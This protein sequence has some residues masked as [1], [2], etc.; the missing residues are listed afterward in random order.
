MQQLRSIHRF[1]TLGIGVFL[2]FLGVTGTAVQLID[3]RSIAFVNSPHDPNVLAMREA[4]DGPGTYAVRQAADYSAAPLPA[5]ID[6]AGSLATVIQA[7]RAKLGNV[8]TSYVEFRMAGKAS[9]GQ[10]GFGKGHLR[11]NPASGEL[12]EQTQIDKRDDQSPESARNTFKRLHRMTTFGN[13]ALYINIFVSLGVAVLIVT[14]IILYWKLYRGR[15]KIK[16][17]GLFWT[18]GGTWRMLHRSISI[19]AS[20]VL[21]V[22][23]SS[24]AW[25]A[26]ESLGM[27]L[28]L[29]KRPP[30]QNSFAPSAPRPSDLLRPADDTSLGTMLN[31]TLK[32][33]RAEAPDDP[34]QVVR[35]RRYS[36]YLQG[37]VVTGGGNSR[38]LV[39]N[40]RT[41]K[42]MRSTEPGYPEV[43]FPFGWEAHQLAKAVH[44][45]S[46]FGLPGRL[47][48][49]LGG[50]A[51]MYLSVSGGI[52]YYSMWRKR[53]DGE[54]KGLLWA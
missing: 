6:Y 52:M 13:W 16:R 35:L 12:L 4:F 27:G 25:L 38:Q 19:C 23:T 48:D 30:G 42:A 51:M 22:I 8:P 34:F 47:L 44:R 28:Y 45:G 10:V 49:L 20:L 53:R 54:R 2:L 50:L 17:P 37:I 29:S 18:G 36:D 33:A 31:V 1:V 15:R 41:G 14:G 5:A 11:F 40:A 32:A 9:V 39:F 26:V 24:G 46:Y 43:G 7:T 21:I 3:L